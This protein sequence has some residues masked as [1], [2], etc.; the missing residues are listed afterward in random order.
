MPG[1]PRVTAV[2]AVAIALGAGGCGRGD[3][4]GGSAAGDG[5]SAKQQLSAY[6][7]AFNRGD[8]A[9]ACALLTAEAQAGVRSLSDRISAPDC[10]GAI[11][12]LS[13]IGEHIRAPR[14]AV[15]VNGERAVAKV[16]SRRPAYRSDALLVKQEG[17]WR[18]AYPPALLERYT[19]PPG[20]PDESRAH[21]RR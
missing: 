17:A 19:S 1:L 2:A 14:I 21:D 10:E 12:E 16:T 20:I 8:G 11:A 13:R 3:D 7:T 9:A 15:D 4:S 5:A 18:I 6:F